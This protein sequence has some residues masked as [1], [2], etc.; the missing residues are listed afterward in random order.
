MLADDYAVV[1]TFSMPYEAQIARASLQAAGIDALIADEHTINMDWFYSNALGGVRLLVHKSQ[2]AEAREL[3]AADF[4]AELP[5]ADTPVRCP[6]CGSEIFRAE[7]EAVARCTGGLVCPAQRKEAL[8]HFA[9]RKAMDVDGLG[10]KL[11]DVLVDQELVHS[12]A[13]LYG[14]SAS[15]QP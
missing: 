12:P 8:K 2:L 10:D 3:V 13:D 7:G 6:A 14:L 5:E 4:S 1:A 11:I 9:S 15:Q